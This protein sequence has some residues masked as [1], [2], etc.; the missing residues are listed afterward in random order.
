MLQLMRLGGWWRGWRPVWQLLNAPGLALRISEWNF[1]ESPGAICYPGVED[2]VNLS[3]EASWRH[4]GAKT[5][6]NPP[7]PFATP[8]WRTP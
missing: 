2:A 3:R 4:P 6:T 7:E 5:S 1:Y 8:V